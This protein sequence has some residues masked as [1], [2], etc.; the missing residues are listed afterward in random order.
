MCE[1]KRY[2]NP[3]CASREDNGLGLLIRGEQASPIDG[4]SINVRAV[5]GASLRLDGVSINV[6]AVRGANLRLEG[7]S[8]NVRAVRGFLTT[9]MCDI[10]VTDV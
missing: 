5:R 4:V 2:V 8:I 1:L 7:V 6:R 10:R 3:R 9:I